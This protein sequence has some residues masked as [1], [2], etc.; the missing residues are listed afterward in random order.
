MLSV[1]ES[2]SG[3]G[4]VWAISEGER[5]PNMGCL[6]FM[7]WGISYAIEWEDYSNFGG[8]GQ[9]FPGIRPLPTFWDF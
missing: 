5:P 1:S 7:G 9:K 8:K 6:A 4:R 2:E 3:L